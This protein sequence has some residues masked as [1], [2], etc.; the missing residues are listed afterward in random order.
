MTIVDELTPMYYQLNRIYIFRDGS[1]VTATA[2]LAILN[3]DGIQ[4]AGDNPVTTLTAGEKTA[5]A[6]FLD[7]ELAAYEAANP[8]LTKWSPP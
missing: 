4:V 6:A 8:P 7:R 1:E 5:L 3:I 2:E